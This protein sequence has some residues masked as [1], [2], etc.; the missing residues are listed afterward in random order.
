MLEQENRAALLLSVLEHLRKLNSWCGETH[1]Q[2]ACYLLQAV[3]NSPMGYRFTLY[4]FAPL[5]FELQDD[6][7]ELIGKE[8]VREV[9]A[10][11]HMGA[12]LDVTEFGRRFLALRQGSLG[13]FDSAAR[14][15]VARIAG[16]KVNELERL[17][18]G[19]YVSLELSHGTEGERV[20]RLIEYQKHITAGEATLA[21]REA[22]V[23]IEESRVYKQQNGIASFVTSSI[24]AS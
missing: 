1:V 18:M 17:T 19:V 21:V 23:L 11:H 8:L 12:S 15:I 14:F 13:S 3:L 2:K 10:G 24:P 6:L 9:P 22:V 20:S 4:K 5:S 16:M 7:S